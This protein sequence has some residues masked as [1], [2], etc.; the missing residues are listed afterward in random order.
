M[1]ICLLV[2]VV[3]DVGLRDDAV[4]WLNQHHKNH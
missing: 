4:G 3:Y 2:Y 1:Y